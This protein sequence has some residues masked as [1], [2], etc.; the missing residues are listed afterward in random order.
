LF[1]PLRMFWSFMLTSDGSFHILVDQVTIWPAL[2]GLQM[3][4]ILR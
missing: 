4:K 1:V 3:A 2:N